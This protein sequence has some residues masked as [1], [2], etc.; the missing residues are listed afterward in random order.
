MSEAVS[1]VVL[2]SVSAFYV[3]IHETE[4]HICGVGGEWMSYS[5]FGNDGSVLGRE[6][7]GLGSGFCVCLLYL[8]VCV[9]LHLCTFVVISVRVSTRNWESK[10][11]KKE[12]RERESE[13]V[14]ALFLGFFGSFHVGAGEG[15]SKC[16]RTED[17]NEK[18]SQRKRWERSEAV[19]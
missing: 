13:R 2:E 3:R 6:G 17:I 5:V 15:K 9:W 10:E 14:S 4:E 11:R 1:L 8:C 18:V 19:T 7:G 16:Q 12:E